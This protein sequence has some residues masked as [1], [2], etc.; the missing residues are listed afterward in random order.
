LVKK[1]LFGWL[2]LFSLCHA[3]GQQRNLEFYFSDSQQV[4]S[5][6]NYLSYELTPL[7]D[8]LLSIRGL[9]SLEQ[10]LNFNQ[11]YR[12]SS[13]ELDFSLARSFWRHSLQSGYEYIYDHN[14]VEQELYPYVN[15]TGYLGYALALEPSDSLSF[16]LGGRGYLRREEDRYEL[17]NELGSQGYLAFARARYHLDLSFSDLGCGAGLERKQLD[18]EFYESAWANASLN[19][20]RSDL[21]FSNDLA[22]RRRKDKLYQLS[23]TGKRG[24]YSVYDVQERS[25]LNYTGSI[26]YLPA[27]WLR[28][29]AFDQYGHHNTDL[30]QNQVRNNADYL[31][32]ANLDLNASL[33]PSLDW[34]SQVGH[35]YSIKDFNYN[36]NTRHI[37]TRSLS[38][39]LAWQY[40]SGDSLILRAGIELQ[41]TSFPDDNNNWDNDLRT[42][43]LRF[44]NVHYWRDRIRLN[45]Q[46]GWTL[47]D[48]VYLKAALSSN[49]KQVNSLVYNPECLILVG[50]RILLSQN[51]SIRADYTDYAYEGKD[52]ALYRQLGYKYTLLFDSFPYVAR[53]GDLRWM[54]LP[55]RSN[56]GNSFLVEASFG[57]EQND[58]ADQVE[59]Y[60]Q[61]NFKNKRYN[62]ILTVKHEI[63]DFYYIIQ[64]SY[65]WGTWKEY[66]LLCGCA[67]EF[68]EDSL[69]EISLNPVGEDGRD[70]DWRLS[71]NLGIH[72]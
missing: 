68:S 16:E 12:Q 29:T 24:V 18:W 25:S 14:D 56:A 11:E 7:K 52:N 49:N 35:T 27:D 5:R 60:Y 66:G 26:E 42:R 1:S 21:A 4:R 44:G 64:P 45:N 6:Q 69:L 54:D 22:L 47:T 48:D 20:Q 55:Y 40:A 2:L 39:Q 59:D 62:T 8:A 67:W 58:Y 51:Y 15:K 41:R 31:N 10:R 32:Q 46:I 43:S 38:S 9:S 36:R 17:G 70:L 63:G 19:L 37:E 71:A 57:Y 28:I 13:L 50:D 3:F 61:I 72:F 65:T 53:S 23:Q 30:E 33:L 34:Q